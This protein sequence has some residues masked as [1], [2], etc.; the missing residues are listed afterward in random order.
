MNKKINQL[1]T[2]NTGGTGTQ[3]LGEASASSA[4]SASSSSNDAFGPLGA[5]KWGDR[6]I[7]QIPPQA[8]GPVP[9]PSSE[10]TPQLGRIKKVKTIKKV[11]EDKKVRKVRAE[12]PKE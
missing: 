9:L 10:G 4:S 1:E 12:A 11:E 3:P 6:V 5:G 2:G 7:K 8:P